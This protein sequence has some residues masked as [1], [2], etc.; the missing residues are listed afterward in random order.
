MLKH[1]KEKAN[2]ERFKFLYSGA[3]RI[4]K[5]GI[6]IMY[7]SFFSTSLKVE[8]IEFHFWTKKCLIY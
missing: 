7:F 5:V 6:F 1:G 3:K 2:P 4:A 8:E